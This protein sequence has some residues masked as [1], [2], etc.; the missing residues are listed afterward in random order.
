VDS[1]VEAQI[2]TDISIHSMAVS[3]IEEGCIK[4]F[5]DPAAEFHRIYV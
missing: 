3:S 5:V 4:L 1:F 2:K